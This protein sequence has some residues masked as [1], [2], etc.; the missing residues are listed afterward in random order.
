MK[1]YVSGLYC[2]T[3][4]QPGVGMARSLRAAY[5][6]AKL[7]GVEYS[8]RCSGIHWTDLDDVWLQ[9]PWEELDL[10]AYGDA[11]TR[12]L[13]AGAIWI[14]GFDLEIMWLATVFPDGHEN[15]L[16]APLRALQRIS[17]PMVKAA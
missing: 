11:V 15:L 9:R 2:G 1:I 4:P 17:K 6:K 10:E 7:I 12:V 16:T 13:D 3:N 14:S 8:P 5:P